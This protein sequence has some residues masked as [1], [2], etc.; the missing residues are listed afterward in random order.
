MYNEYQEHDVA[1]AHTSCS[2]AVLL[3]ADNVSL[4]M[5]RE[6]SEPRGNLDEDLSACA[7]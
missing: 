2:M 4:T 1:V 3:I 6:I 7:T 5:A